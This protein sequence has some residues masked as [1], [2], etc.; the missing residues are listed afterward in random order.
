MAR[1][2][3]ALAAVLAIATPGGALADHP[4]ASVP[5]TSLLPARQAPAQASPARGCA[6]PSPRCVDRVIAEM[7][8]RWTPLDRDCDHRAVFALTYLRTTEAFRRALDAAPFADAE[9]IIRLDAVFAGLYFEAE[10]LA[11][12]GDPAV[13]QAW[14]IAFEAADAR[15]TNAFQD[16]VLGMNAHIQRDLPV[17][18]YRM[19]LVGPGG[20]RK[21]DHDRVN[22]V[23]AAVVDEIED[24][25]AARYDPAFS[26]VDAK[27]S[28]A[29]EIA[30]LESIRTWR[31]GAW[32]NAERLALAATPEERA[33]VMDS[34]ERYAEA[35]ALAIATPDFS[36]YAPVREGHCRN[37]G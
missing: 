3:I 11:A 37:A 1:R 10:D 33:G 22:D 35:W 8:R 24:E 26:V 2:G 27:P 6:R 9:W 20:S 13:P 29:D 16:V 25:I 31:E 30:A 15:R 32:R 14:R 19:G 4:A 21:P 23:L 34:I 18:L 28:P 7:E 36:W 12:E 17:A 5:W